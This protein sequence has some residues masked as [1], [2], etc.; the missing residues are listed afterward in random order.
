VFGHDCRQ[1]RQI[2]FQLFFGLLDF[3][4]ALLYGLDGFGFLAMK[5]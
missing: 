3:V 1:F 5:E 2:F 4:V